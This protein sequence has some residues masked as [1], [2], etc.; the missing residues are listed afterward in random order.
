MRQAQ[1][2]GSPIRRG[3]SIEPRCSGERPETL[4]VVFSHTVCHSPGR[5]RGLG[6]LL[7]SEVTFDAKP[8]RAPRLNQLSNYFWSRKWDRKRAASL[9]AVS[10]SR[11]VATMGIGAIPVTPRA[12]IVTARASTIP[13]PHPWRL[14]L[15]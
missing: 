15:G 2:T 9:I 11:P 4:L 13:L 10:V 12:F 5:E 6:A 7:L 14:V 1:G 3:L 8:R